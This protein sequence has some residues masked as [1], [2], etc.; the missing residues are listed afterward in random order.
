MKG[1]ILLCLV[2][3]W[4]VVFLSGCESPSAATDR[5][6]RALSIVHWALKQDSFWAYVEGEARNISKETL[7]YAEVWANFFNKHGQRLGQGVT[8]TLAL[9]PNETWV[10]RVYYVGEKKD[11]HHAEVFVGNCS[12]R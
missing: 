8:N 11:V 5:A 4:A 3:L 2:L 6:R 12:F 7:A 1:R 10:F 9:R